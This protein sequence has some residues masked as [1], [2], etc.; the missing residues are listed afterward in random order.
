VLFSSKQLLHLKGLINFN[1]IGVW[2]GVPICLY[3]GQQNMLSTLRFQKKTSVMMTIVWMLNE[4]NDVFVYRAVREYNRFY[5][6]HGQ[7]SRGLRS[8]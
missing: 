7:N 4:L 6:I 1:Q 2:M 8:I 5:V 3:H